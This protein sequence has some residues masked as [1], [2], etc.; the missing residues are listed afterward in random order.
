VR[1][2]CISSQ[3]HFN[4]GSRNGLFPDTSN[5]LHR[6]AHRIDKTSKLHPVLSLCIRRVLH[7]PILAFL[8]A[9]VCG[10]NA[11]IALNAAPKPEL[12]AARLCTHE[13]TS[14][15][16]PRSREDPREDPC[17]FRGWARASWKET[18]QFGYGLKTVPRDSVRVDNLKWELPIAATTGVLIGAVDQRADS[19]IH[20]KS[21]Q[22]TAG[23][24]SNFG[25]GVE[26]GAG[27]LAYGLGCREHYSYVRDTGF[28]A[29]AAMGT[30]G[31]VDLILKLSFDRQFP[32]TP[33]ST[34]QFWG[35][36]RS[37]PS[38]HS[39]TSFAFAAVIAHRYPHKKWLKWAAYGLAT[40]VA[41]SRYP[42]KRHYLSDILVGSTVGYLIGSYMAEH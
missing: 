9:S 3:S 28:R 31:T 14:T 17:G 1:Q 12:F 13:N 27:G 35:G 21:I 5:S 10:Q 19:R 40:G 2:N 8:G 16:A 22:D 11:P 23:F 20:G 41:L 34:G 29:L 26:I 6:L 4:R 24:W 30:A 38:G 33:N 42:G 15:A 32:F 18:K 36:G 37:F 7:V 25:L 39:A